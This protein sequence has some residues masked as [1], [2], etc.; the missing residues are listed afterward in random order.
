MKQTAALAMHHLVLKHHFL[1]CPIMPHY[2]TKLWEKFLLLCTI[3]L[4][5]RLTSGIQKLL[6]RWE[7]VAIKLIFVLF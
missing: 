1:Y 7:G 3:Y 4:S 5:K 6:E 2:V